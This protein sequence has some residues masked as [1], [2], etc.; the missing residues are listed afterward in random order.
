MLLSI[1]MYSLREAVETEGL[2]VVLQAVAESGFSGVELAGTYGLPPEELRALL[3]SRGL[4]AT[5][6]HVGMDELADTQK[7]ADT[8]RALGLTD[9]I[10]AWSNGDAGNMDV[11]QTAA[12]ALTG[13]RVGYHN[14]DHEFAP[15][16]KAFL[17]RLLNSKVMLEPDI[18]WLKAAG[19]DP[20]KFL[21]AYADRVL[22]VHMKELSSEGVKACN[23]APGCGVSGCA[24]AL[25]F[26]IQQGHRYIVLEFERLNVPYR[27]Y[28]SETVAFVKSVLEAR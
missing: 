10:V 28:L 26:A 21:E 13:F 6:M 12:D 9:I 27:Q 18:F 15:P 25:R 2:A 11:I 8:A 20:M 7:L 1:Q 17:D 22:A 16:A 4:I 5:G 24:D 14:H 19:R 23:P 3:D